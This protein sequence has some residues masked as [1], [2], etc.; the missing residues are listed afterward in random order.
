MY[1]LYKI[2]LST[3]I[4]AILFISCLNLCTKKTTSNMYHPNF[5]KAPAENT[6]F[7]VTRCIPSPVRNGPRSSVLIA[8]GD[9]HF[10]SGPEYLGSCRWK[11][12][13]L[14]GTRGLLHLGL[15]KG[16]DT[17]VKG[18]G[19]IDSVYIELVS[20]LCICEYLGEIPFF[21]GNVMMLYW[22]RPFQRPGFGGI[23]IY[24]TL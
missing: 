4:I 12:S 7:Q 5:W 6:P 2:N 9:Y 14:P 16:E 10:W 15:F 17:S 20:I 23:K 3:I 13:C 22:G 11:S 1:L 24:A 18:K 8:W 19:H 21:W